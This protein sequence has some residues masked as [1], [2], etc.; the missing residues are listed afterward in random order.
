MG[1]RKKGGFTWN[2]RSAILAILV[3]ALWVEAVVALA[4]QVQSQADAS[5]WLYAIGFFFAVLPILALVVY[6][7]RLVFD[8]F[9]SV[10]VGVTNLVFIGLGSIAGVLF[11]QE[12][13]N[14]PIPPP[15]EERTVFETGRYQHYQ[16]FRKAHAYFTYHLLHGLGYHSLPMVDRECLIDEEQTETQLGRLRENLPALRDRFGEEYSVALE[17]Q[18]AAGLRNRQAN[19]EIA[20]LE[21]R[22]DDGWWTLFHYAD[23]LDLLRVYKSDWFASFWFIL[24]G[25]VL[26][27]TFRGGWRRLLRPRKWGFVVTHAGVLL[28]VVGAYYGRLTEMRG[29]LQMHVGDV[30]DRFREYNGNITPFQTPTLIGDPD[31]PFVVR[32]ESF[33]ADHHDVVDVVFAEEGPD[34]GFRQEFQLK[35]PKVRVYAGQVLYY[36]YGTGSSEHLP[37]ERRGDSVPYLRVEVEEYLPQAEVKRVLQAAEPTDPLALP[38]ARL[39]V[40]ETEGS[41]ETERLLA[42]LFDLP[43]L[44]VPLH[45]PHSGSKVLYRLVRDEEEMAAALETTV[46]ER[47][48]VLRQKF[49]GDVLSDEVVDVIPGARFEVEAEERRY[50]VEIVEAVPTLIP[51]ST[52]NG[53]FS[54]E[55]SGTEVTRE[56]ARLPAVQLRITAPNGDEEMRWVMEQ[57]FHAAARRFEDVQFAF[58]WDRWAAPAEQRWLVFQLVDGRCFAGRIGEPESLRPVSFGDEIALDEGH[59]LVLLEAYPSATLELAAEALSGVDFFHPAPAAVSL[60]VSSPEWDERFVM[61]AEEGSWKELRYNGPD[62][63][64]RIALLRFRPDLDDLPL[65]WRSKLTFLERQEDGNYEEVRSGEIRVNDY[66]YHRGFRFFQTDADAADPLYSGIGI[67]YDPGI[68]MV[69][70]GLYMVTGGTIIVFLIT[71]VLT[72]RIRGA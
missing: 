48:G 33:R 66:L 37:E 28:T 36:D 20:L 56:E 40:R 52:G 39:A 58:S 68:E 1:Q 18:S 15:S 10:R 61:S 7:W 12:D 71:P 11:Y 4:T 5:R 21:T 69:L 62:G 17:A 59:Q 14:F 51:S 3:L 44:K 13:P 50:Q 42:H 46:V 67:V 43:F 6:R 9:R 55:P 22:W 29:I 63:R 49:G 24:V 41:I 35:P 30:S 47:F 45:H 2:F 32:L 65:E 25:G 16:Q 57:E 27:N 19:A 38:M 26:S 72:R 54:H 23:R 60:R 31:D 8:F 64:E 34:G 53:G 70:L